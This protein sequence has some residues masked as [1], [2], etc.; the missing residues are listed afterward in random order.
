MMVLAVDTEN[1]TYNIGAPF[2]GRFKGV[3]HSWADEG[4]S[5]AHQNNP[6]SL[7]QLGERIERS[8]VLVGFNLK[9]DLHVLRKLGVT[10]WMRDDQRFWDCQIAEFIRSNQTWKYPSLDESCSKYGL[11]KKIDVIAENYWKN[12]IQTEDIPW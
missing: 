3:C 5:G 10:Q 4:G 11:G 2:D 1:N 9:Y 7:A 6:D 8:S 12:Q